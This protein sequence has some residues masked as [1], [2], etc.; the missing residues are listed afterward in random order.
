MFL[1]LSFFSPVAWAFPSSIPAFKS[2]WGSGHFPKRSQVLWKMICSAT[3]CVIW[4][5]HNRRIFRGN[6]VPLEVLICRIRSNLIQWALSLS[7]FSR[8][9][10][11]RILHDLLHL[12]CI[13]ILLA[14]QSL[15]GPVS[16]SLCFPNLEFNKM[17]PRLSK[18]TSTRR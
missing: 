11:G 13:R 7:S 8:L 14:G 18:E 2:E 5:E 6:S 10:D 15:D 4:L 3:L 9:D 16:F 17:L 12:T 1:L